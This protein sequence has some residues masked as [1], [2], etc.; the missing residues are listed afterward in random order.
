MQLLRDMEAVGLDAR[1]IKVATGGLDESFLWTNLATA[2]VM[3]RVAR[4]MRRF[5]VSEQGAVLG[6]GG[7]FETLVVDGPACLF[8]KRI[9]VDEADQR[10]IREGGY[11]AWLRV[12]RASVQDKGEQG[13]DELDE[14]P[15]R[16]SLLDV[17]FVDML[18]K[19][20][21]AD[22]DSAADRGDPAFSSS[23]DLAGP[24][25]LGGFGGLPMKLQHWCV[26]GDADARASIES[27]TTSLVDK[28]R[29]RLRQESLE[30]SAIIST[31]IILRRMADFPEIN[32]IYGALF[33]EPNPPSRVTISCGEQLPP[34]CS[35]VVYLALQ[36]DIIQRQRKGLHVQSRSYW[37]PANIGP[38]S[39]AISIPLDSLTSQAITET[40]AELVS[41]AG[42]I[43]L[44]PASMQFPT[45]G[46][47][48]LE[49]QLA[50]SLQHLWR[51][52]LDVGVQW[53]SSAVAFF[54]RAAPDAMSTNVRLAADAWELA[55]RWSLDAGAADDGEDSED[56][57]PDL[58]DRKYNP[59]YASYG[60]EEETKPP[61]LPDLSVVAGSGTA[62]PPFFAAEVQQLPRSALVEWQAHLGFAR[63]D[64]DSVRLTLNRTRTAGLEISNT[65]VYSAKKR[66][67]LVSSIWSWKWAN[68]ESHCRRDS[69]GQRL[70]VDQIC[71]WLSGQ[72]LQSKHAVPVVQYFDSSLYDMPPYN[73][74][75]HATAVPAIPCFSLWNGEGERL[76]IVIVYHSVALNGT[77]APEE[78]DGDD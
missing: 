10:V 30:P 46:P 12:H 53:W 43:P 36:P 20:G 72:E 48:A 13:P 26:V 50:L 24:P 44:I 27:E 54:P 73:M 77:P 75:G 63:L 37:A 2:P 18:G 59:A 62:F 52:G 4:G 71:S 61:G 16:P 68:A 21:L 47:R 78:S 3:S 8:K 70:A 67:S 9:V 19:L 14:L 31:T 60:A 1:I 11:S 34:G 5:M 49:L 23:G 69:R 66:T 39:Q 29:L 76:A 42:Q 28:I 58:W 33:A 56:D 15:R 41:I 22:E 64:P 55:H 51:I 17:R 45:F 7:E 6:E 40:G 65:V 32:G 57:G 35:I 74:D 25:S 38:Y